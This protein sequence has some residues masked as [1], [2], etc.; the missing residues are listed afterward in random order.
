MQ[1]SFLAYMNTNFDRSRQATTHVTIGMMREAMIAQRST[2]TDYLLTLYVHR[3]HTIHIILGQLED[4]LTTMEAALR[5]SNGMQGQAYTSRVPHTGRHLQTRGLG[6]VSMTLLRPSS[7]AFQQCWL[8]LEPSSTK[9]GIGVVGG[10]H[11]STLLYSIIDTSSTAL[12]QQAL[13]RK[14]MPDRG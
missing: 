12:H 14:V 4:Q 8:V 11:L 7:K 3:V 1:L 2:L 5:M 6:K 13:Y 9:M 10:C